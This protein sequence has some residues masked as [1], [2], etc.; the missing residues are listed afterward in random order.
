MSK[1]IIIIKSKWS[2]LKF[3]CQ[4]YIRLLLISNLFL[5][6]ISLNKVVKTFIEIFML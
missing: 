1:L 3:K 4:K 5:M 2:C 6:I